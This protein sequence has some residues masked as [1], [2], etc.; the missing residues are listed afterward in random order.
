MHPFAL[1]GLGT[2]G[3]DL[4]AVVAWV[5]LTGFALGFA[6]KAAI[7]IFYRV[8]S[9]N[10]IYQKSGDWVF[11]TGLGGT[12]EDDNSRYTVL[13]NEEDKQVLI[14][15]SL[16]FTNTLIVNQ[17]PENLGETLNLTA[18]FMAMHLNAKLLL[19]GF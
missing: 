11:V 18:S 3:V 1:T 14:P 19:P 4:N 6:L 16:P 17:F 15:N 9:I 12:V 8:L 13:R 10:M 7:S 5:G 2:A